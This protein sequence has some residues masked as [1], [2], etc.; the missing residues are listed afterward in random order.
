MW[1]T[2]SWGTALVFN[3]A[4]PTSSTAQLHASPVLFVSGVE[5]SSPIQQTLTYAW[6]TH[7][8]GQHQWCPPILG[9]EEK[10]KEWKDTLWKTKHEQPWTIQAKGESDILTPS[11][12]FTAAPWSHSSCMPEEQSDIAFKSKTR[13]K[14]CMHLS[15]AFH[16]TP[17]YPIPQSAT[18]LCSMVALSQGPTDP[19]RPL[20]THHC[21]WVS[22][23]RCWVVRE[24]LLHMHTPKA[25]YMKDA[26]IL[27]SK[28]QA[29]NHQLLVF[30][31]M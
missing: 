20:R 23:G 22:Q 11:L 7:L 21:P 31:S 4:K 16:K 19:E 18:R 27:W 26:N 29:T 28:V 1:K 17:Q 13:R 14:R 30:W 5:V 10:I 2:E 24:R 12:A 15:T 6:T 3:N 8:S 25:C 9:K